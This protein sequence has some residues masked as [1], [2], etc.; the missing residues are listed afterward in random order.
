VYR[1][2]VLLGLLA[3]GALL[4]A[5][6]S[7]KQAPPPAPGG[8]N[9]TV[10]VIPAQYFSADAESAANLT[11]GIRQ[12]FTSKGWNVLPTETVK[13][14]W[15]AM[16]MKNGVHYPDKTAIELGQKVNADLVVY[17][18]LLAL[19]IP[20]PMERTGEPG[21][22]PAAVVHLRVMNVKRNRSIYFN[23]IAQEYTVGEPIQVASFQLPSAVA[24]TA[25]TQVL[26]GFFE[27]VAG[28]RQVLAPEPPR[29][30]ARGG[31]R[32]GRRAAK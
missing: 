26:A 23:Q 10:A 19:G 21:L 25:S 14:A 32:G 24:Q 22:K 28:S 3:A 7:A 17:P 20:I 18:R 5:S 1:P 9:L 6:A 11:E 2:I 13:S 4:A 16:G 8:Q 31:R 27:R 30:S 29:M 15:D 12:D